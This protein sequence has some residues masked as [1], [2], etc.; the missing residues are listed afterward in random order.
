MK[1]GS[2]WEM[3]LHG[4]AERNFLPHATPL[5]KRFNQQCEGTMDF[6]KMKQGKAAKAL[7]IVRQTLASWEKS[8]CP[9]ND[10]GTYSLPDV[11]SWAIERAKSECSIA[12]ASPESDMWLSE[13]RKQKALIAKLQRET[14]EGKLIPEEKIKP[15]WTMRMA[16]VARHLQMLPD[17]L[18]P[19]LE[20]LDQHGMRKVIDDKQCEIREMFCRHGEYCD[21]ALAR[22]FVEI[23]EAEGFFKETTNG[24]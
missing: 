12:P 18:P 19:L 23:L 11:F 16:E 9:R 2:S 7:G 24:E 15:A 6:L 14:M 10:D 21:G 13:F 8:G 5:K 20:G 1:V 17:Q 3:K 22:R 4:P